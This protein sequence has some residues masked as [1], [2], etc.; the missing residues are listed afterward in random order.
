[1]NYLLSIDQ[2]TT[3]S[4]V[5]VFN[6]AGKLIAQHQK[7]FTQYYPQD[8]WV[9]HDAEEIWKVTLKCL[10]EVIETSRIL[11]SD[12]AAVGI[13]N[14]RE[15]TVLWDKKTGR[16]LYNAIV[17]QDRRTAEQC[18][19]LKSDSQV[20]KDIMEKT[21]LLLDP[22]FSATKIAWL[23]D[24]VKG[25]RL[26]AERGEL[27][28]GTV[29]SFLLWHLTAGTVFATDATN[30]AR[31]LLYNIH[32]G[33]WDDD[34]L[35]LFSIP[36]ACLADVKDSSGVFGCCDQAIFGAAVPISAVLGD[37]QAATVGQA[38]FNSGMVK[39]TYGTGCFM[40]LNTGQQVVTSTSRL[41]STIAYQ[42]NG[43]PTYALEGSIFIAGAAVTWL[44]DALRFFNQN[45]ETQ[46]LALSVPDNGGVYL[47]PAFTGLGAPYWDPHARGALL[48]LTRDTQIEH[49]VRA[50]LEAV[51]YQSRDLLNAM[52]IDSG[53]NISSLRVD[54]G[55]VANDWLLQFLADILN[56]KVERP[57][58]IESS[59]LGAAL[60][61][62]LG[63]GLYS[64][65]SDLKTIW[66]CSQVLDPTMQS[67][68]R[69][70]LYAGWKEAVSCITKD[71]GLHTMI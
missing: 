30:A 48:G 55:M 53:L 44:R 1:M 17:W 22:Y 3:S 26:K 13:S 62:G 24:N 69:E 19:R 11:L 20:E 68:Q 10:H 57:H 38:C 15:T 31:T 56:V 67:I 50:A 51:C 21:G 66:S 54:G 45:N 29:D 71:N 33:C 28:C 9:E 34:L 42:V 18:E 4:R 43:V 46:S 61:A 64:D 16:P 41:L 8:G 52:S 12:I 35:S 37:Q 47:V 5:I 36:R 59:A 40:V 49:I 14:Q 58:C 23:L 32:D 63:V 7:E 25:A 70:Q 39:S 6:E 65:F 60:F 27:A 2:G